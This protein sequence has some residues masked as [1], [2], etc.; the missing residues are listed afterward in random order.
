MKRRIKFEVSILL[1]HQLMDPD[2]FGECMEV[3][4]RKEF[5]EVVDFKFEVDTDENV[6]DNATL[7]QDYF[8]DVE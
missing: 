6:S 8:E 4:V 7:D 2:V 3:A 1:T 5:G